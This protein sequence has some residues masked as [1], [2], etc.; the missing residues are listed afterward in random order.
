MEWANKIVASMP[1][2]VHAKQTTHL[3]LALQPQQAQQWQSSIR[4]SPPR[5][6][7]NRL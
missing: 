5:I 4:W 3:K 2:C 6:S 1:C 7:W